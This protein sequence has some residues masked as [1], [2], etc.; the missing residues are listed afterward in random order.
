MKIIGIND[1]CPCGSDK[2]YKKCCQIALDYWN[3]YYDN[4]IQDKIPFLDNKTPFE[5][6]KTEK[7]KQKVI[8]LI[9]DFENKNLRMIQKSVGGNIQRFFNADE[10]RKRLIYNSNIPEGIEVTG[11]GNPSKYQKDLAQLSEKS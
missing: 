11:I 7:G 5:A 2:K 4:W 10:L 9:D 3:K 1:P 6:I 8:D